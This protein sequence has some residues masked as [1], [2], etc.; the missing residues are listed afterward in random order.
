MKHTSGLSRDAR[1]V[2]KELIDST[3]IFRKNLVNSSSL[4]R[5]REQRID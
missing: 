3:V 1:L 4:S 5:D 2:K